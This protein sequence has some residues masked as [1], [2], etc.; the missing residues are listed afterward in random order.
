MLNCVFNTHYI[1]HI[2]ENY[3][4]LIVKGVKLV[5]MGKF[6]DQ[7]SG[8]FAT[9]LKKQQLQKIGKNNDNAFNSTIQM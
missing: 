5:I 4:K 6:N 2:Y 1:S 8:Y 9:E 7:Q 3:L